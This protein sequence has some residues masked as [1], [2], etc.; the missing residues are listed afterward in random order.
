MVSARASPA[1]TVSGLVLKRPKNRSF[2]IKRSN[3]YKKT[4]KIM[5]SSFINICL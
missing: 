4:I 2:D 1:A 5:L 3:E